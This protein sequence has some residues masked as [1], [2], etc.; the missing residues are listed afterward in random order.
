MNESEMT[1][2]KR[3]ANNAKTINAELKWTK[4]TELS[5]K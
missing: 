3:I 2:E 5:G 4:C 1:G